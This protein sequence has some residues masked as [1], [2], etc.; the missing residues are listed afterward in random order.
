MCMNNSELI[1]QP[2]RAMHLHDAQQSSYQ[3]TIE[4]AWAVDKRVIIRSDRYLNIRLII[5]I[6]AIREDRRNVKGV[7]RMQHRQPA[8]NA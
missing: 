3:G 1:K 5:D 6:N 8:H 2:H 4:R 7:N